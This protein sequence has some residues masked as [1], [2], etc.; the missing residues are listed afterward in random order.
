MFFLLRHYAQGYGDAAKFDVRFR[1][2]VPRIIMA[3]MLMGWVLWGTYLLLQP[4]FEMRLWRHLAFFTMLS[5]G[6]VSYI[7]IGQKIGAF[8]VTDFKRAVKKKR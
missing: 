1:R 2:R 5:I 3:S 4:V 6:L 7:W 8:K